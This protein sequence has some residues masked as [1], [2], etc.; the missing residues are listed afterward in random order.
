MRLALGPYVNRPRRALPANVEKG[1]RGN[2]VAELVASILPVV[3]TWLS[4]GK[5]FADEGQIDPV[6]ALPQHCL[7]YG[8]P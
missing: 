2:Q 4:L 6:V 5:S 1:C 8:R 7:Q 3:E